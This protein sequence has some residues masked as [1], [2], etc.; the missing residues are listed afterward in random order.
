MPTMAFPGDCYKRHFHIATED[1]GL[2]RGVGRGRGPG[3][4][5]PQPSHPA[6]A[7]AAPPSGRGSPTCGPPPVT[8]ICLSTLWSQE[9]IT[10]QMCGRSKAFRRRVRARALAEGRCGK[11]ASN[12]EGGESAREKQRE[13]EWGRET[14]KVRNRDTHTGE[15]RRGRSERETHRKRQRRGETERQHETE[16]KTETQKEPGRPG[17]RHTPAT[18]AGWGAA[19]SHTLRSQPHGPGFSATVSAQ[20]N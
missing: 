16:R 13:R 10:P 9:T 15:R 11:Q 17:D 4:A 12:K 6:E 8:I 7:S 20:G 14:Q 19:G 2:A 18:A 5:T 1:A 3:E